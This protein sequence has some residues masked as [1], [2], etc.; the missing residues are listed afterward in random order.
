MKRKQQETDSALLTEVRKSYVRPK[1]KVLETDIEK[2]LLTD[3]Y[4][5]VGATSVEGWG[6]DTNMGPTA[7]VT[8]P[9]E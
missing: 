2:S 7:P 4:T 1:I 8:D 5:R 9:D 3:S 6:G